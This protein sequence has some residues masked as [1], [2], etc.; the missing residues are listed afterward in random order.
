MTLL[1]RHLQEDIWNFGVAWSRSGGGSAVSLSLSTHSKL[2]ITEDSIGKTIVIL[3]KW[4]CA[5]TVAGATLC[6][7]T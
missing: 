6:V 4:S 2:I 1:G 3:V 5:L 7:L